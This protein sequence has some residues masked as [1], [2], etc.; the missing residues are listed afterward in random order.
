MQ[1][2]EHFLSLSALSSDLQC[3]LLN[4]CLGQLKGRHIVTYLLG[5]LL[6]SL[7]P[8]LGTSFWRLNEAGTLSLLAS[9]P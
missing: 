5:T 4:L 9:L 2:E 7:L 3:H 1:S 8:N 6:D